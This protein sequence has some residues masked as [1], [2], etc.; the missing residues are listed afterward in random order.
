M[1]LCILYIYNS[2]IKKT[3]FPDVKNLIEPWNPWFNLLKCWYIIFFN[4]IFIGWLNYW[5]HSMYLLLTALYNYQHYLGEILFNWAYKFWLFFFIYIN[6]MIHF[7]IFNNMLSIQFNSNQK[8]HFCLSSG[9]KLF[10]P[11]E[12]SKWTIMKIFINI[13]NFNHSWIRF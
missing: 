2:H 5:D 1:Q 12:R 7:S 8:K 3:H 13:S 11:S 10:M 9:I 4:F 6:K